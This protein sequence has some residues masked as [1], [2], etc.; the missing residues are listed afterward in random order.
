MQTNNGFGI[1]S[2]GHGGDDPYIDAQRIYYPFWAAVPVT[3]PRAMPIVRFV[4]WHGN[5]YHQFR[6]YTQR[7]SQNTDWH[8]A[9]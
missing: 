3:A 2:F 8:E 9:A 5:L 4:D 6:Y 7:F 1:I